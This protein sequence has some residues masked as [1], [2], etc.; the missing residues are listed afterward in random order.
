[1]CL[2]TRQLCRKLLKRVKLSTL[3]HVWWAFLAWASS[4]DV[5]EDPACHEAGGT[6][7]DSSRQDLH[8][9]HRSQK[10]MFQPRVHHRRRE[11]FIFE[12]WR[13]VS[14][15]PLSL[16]QSCDL[17]S[18]SGVTRGYIRAMA[19]CQNVALFVSV[20]CANGFIQRAP[21]W[22]KMGSDGRWQAW[23]RRGRPGWAQW[24]GPST[25]GHV[26]L[27]RDTHCSLPKWGRASLQMNVK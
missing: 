15:A 13:P 5:G 6:G 12:S 27:Q 18:A 11:A 22:S 4:C 23:Q 21:L 17:F 10:A 3:C 19:A 16:W 26:L 24:G 2:Q 20:D 25:A 9:S 7:R 14:E 8:S 1:M